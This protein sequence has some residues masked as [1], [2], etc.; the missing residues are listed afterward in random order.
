MWARASADKGC[1]RPAATFRGTALVTLN[2]TAKG[3]PCHPD[4]HVR[5]GPLRGLGHAVHHRLAH[6]AA[7]EAARGARVAELAR[8]GDAA[9]AEAVEERAADNRT[10]RGT[11]G[12]EQRER[13]GARNWRGVGVAAGAPFLHRAARHPRLLHDLV[14]LDAKLLI[15]H[16]LN[17]G[18]GGH[19]SSIE[20]R[21]DARLHAIDA[22]Q[23]DQGRLVP[24]IEAVRVVDVVAGPAEKRGAGVQH[25]DAA[26]QS[27]LFEAAED[28]LACLLQRRLPEVVAVAEESTR[29]KWHGAAT[30]RHLQVERVEQGLFHSLGLVHEVRGLNLKRSSAEADL[31][32][33]L[34]FLLARKFGGRA[35]IGHVPVLGVYDAKGE[36]H[37]ILGLPFPRRD[38]I[39]LLQLH[40]HVVARLLALVLELCRVLDANVLFLIEALLLLLDHR[41]ALDVV[42]AEAG[43]TDA[44]R[45]GDVGLCDLLLHAAHG[46]TG[47]RRVCVGRGQDVF[48]FS[49]WRRA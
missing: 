28:R 49:V 38:E 17:R 42:A 41:I 21:V 13:M 37:L 33:A 45:A 40:E 18:D 32:R 2:C 15:E 9:A 35:A 4:R 16:L 43:R 36:L 46:S 34:V 27:V 20:A 48:W 11:V 7:A 26:G 6:K 1:A 29:A 14:P 3:V 47:R 39:H 44:L 30:E 5:R 12:W 22:V 31:D 24:V 8:A 10:A 25:P 19:G 23:L